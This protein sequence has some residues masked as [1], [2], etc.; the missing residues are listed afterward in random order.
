M[1]S[2]VRPDSGGGSVPLVT[3][4]AILS[5][6][7]DRVLPS[8]TGLRGEA[9]LLRAALQA[10]HVPDIRHEGKRFRIECACGW[11]TPLGWTRKRVFQACDEHVRE[12][13]RAAVEERRKGAA[14]PPVN[15]SA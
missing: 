1:G 11:S 3:S 9:N 7:S 12:A 5:P 10:G 4:R 8:E 15:R 2:A 13:G 6:M 14:S